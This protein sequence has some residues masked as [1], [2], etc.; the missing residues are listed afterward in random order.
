MMR[1]LALG[2]IA[3]YQRHISPH[4]GFVCAY[5][6]HTGCGSCSRLGQRAIR[7]Y[8]V[9]K[10]TQLLFARF[11]KCAQAHRRYGGL[12]AASSFARRPGGLTQQRGFVDCACDIPCAGME[13]GT[14]FEVADSCGACPCDLFDWSRRWRRDQDERR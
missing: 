14:F 5:R 10:G 13:C 9:I 3:F 1:F 11:E 6:A 12:A 2:A 7:R 4:K 8:G